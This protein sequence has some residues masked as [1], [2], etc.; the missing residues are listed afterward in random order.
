VDDRGVSQQ[1]GPGVTAASTEFHARLEPFRGEVVAYCYRMLGSVHDAEDLVQDTY[2]RAWRARDQYDEERASVRTWLYRIATNVCLTALTDRGR[3]PLPSGLVAPREALAPFALDAE[4][5][6]LQPLPDALVAAA[7]PAS[8]A[9]DRSSLRLAFVAAVQHLSPR[10]RGAL[11]LREVLSFSAAESA[12]ILGISVAAVNSSLQRAR[13]RMK[14]ANLRELI[15]EPSAA[16]QRAWVERYMTAFERA[17]VEALTRLLTHDVVMEMPPLLNWFA[18]VD[19]YGLFMDWVFEANGT[20]WRVLPV[21]AN[22]QPAF[23][24]Y[25][26]VGRTYQLHT[27]QVLTVTASG[28]SH[29]TVFQDDAIFATFGLSTILTTPP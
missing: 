5:T 9:V 7:D 3:R 19:N 4:I 29:N 14:A 20:D 23:A 13:A 8:T 10:E 25:N 21:A 18:G 24:A 6:W 22:G 27:L 2:L 17:D 26:R 1:P 28:I 15:D 11:I 12:E 16:E